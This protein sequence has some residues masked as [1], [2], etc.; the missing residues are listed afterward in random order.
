MNMKLFTFFDTTA[1]VGIKADQYAS[2]MVQ[3][4]KKAGGE[5]YYIKLGNGD[6]TTGRLLVNRNSL[7]IVENN[8]I[9]AADLTKRYIGGIF[10][11]Y[12]EI[13]NN[14]LD[15]TALVLFRK[16]EPPHHYF[17]KNNDDYLK[18][19]KPGEKLIITNLY[20]EDFTIINNLEARSKK[21]RVEIDDN[22]FTL[23]N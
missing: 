9:Y 14:P 19:I 22:I 13:E 23:L 10:S 20:G 7:T 17:L 2:V 4:S 12:L 1:V 3:G 21:T 6:I 15:T 18:K 5:D 16:I 8:R 11:D